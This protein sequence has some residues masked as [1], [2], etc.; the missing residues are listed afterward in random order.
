MSTDLLV[1]WL[2]DAHAMETALVPV[3]QNHAKDA[4]TAMPDVS[5]RYE[6]HAEETRQH[7]ERVRQA[8]ERLGEK[9]STMK[10]ALS[11]LMGPIQGVSTGMFSDELVKNALVDFSTEQFEVACYDALIAA[12]QEMGEVEIAG[13]CREN[14]A[15]E[16]AMADFLEEQLPR[17]VHQTMQK[18]G[19]TES[20]D[21]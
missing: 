8:L 16:Q 20:R 1:A 21:R 15:E 2:R 9:P 12:A 19:A 13:L 14:L 6:Q 10:S 11:A 17:V 18:A 3:L 4:D 5:R 7:A